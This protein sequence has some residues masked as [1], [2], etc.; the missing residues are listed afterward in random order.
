MIKAIDLEICCAN[1]Y[2]HVDGKLLVNITIFNSRQRNVIFTYI[3][4]SHI[5][6]E[7]VTELPCLYPSLFL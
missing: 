4:L 2:V 6:I 5:P 1:L 7:I 3:L